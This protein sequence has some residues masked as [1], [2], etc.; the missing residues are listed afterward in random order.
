I[1]K[2][3]LDESQYAMFSQKG[4]I[5]FAIWNI[6]SLV[7]FGAAILR[8]SPRILIFGGASDLMWRSEA[9]FSIQVRR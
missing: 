1:A 9:A 4:Q 3:V 8:S 6:K 7:Q 5:D 2:D